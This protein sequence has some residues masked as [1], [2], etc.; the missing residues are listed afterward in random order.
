MIAAKLKQTAVVA[1]IWLAMAASAWAAP[2]E[3]E[4]KPQ[5]DAQSQNA[6][7]EAL[8]R[9]IEA[10]YIFPDTASQTIAAL[11]DKAQR[12]A[13][14]EMR[15]SEQFAAALTED[16]RRLA[17][18]KHFRLEF[19]PSFTPEGNTVPSTEQVAEE[20]KDVA[21]MAWGIRRVE[22][23]AGNVGYLD[24]R[25]FPPSYLVGPAYQSVLSLLS[26]TDA[27]ILDLRQNRGGDP[28]SV[29]QLLSYFFAPG[30]ERH[31]NDIYTRTSNTTRAFWTNP[32]VSLH[33]ARP[34]YVLTSSQTFSGGEECAYDFQTQQRG[35]LVGETTG[36][37]ANPVGPFVLP[38]G[39][40]VAIPIGRPINP[41]TKTNW[42]RVGVK[43][44]VPV[45]AAK[46]LE[47]A[48]RAAL[49]GLLKEAS[50]PDRRQS[51]QGVLARLDKGE[52]ELPAY[53]P[54]KR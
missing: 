5:L 47:T 15:S 10:N 26:G 12:G 8:A 18:D 50:D 25:G 40:V 53:R 39:F 35:T 14:R 9:Q 22:R 54:T 46:A 48:W 37:A 31:L 49:S 4:A 16:L 28:A 42:E 51:L 36:G 38:H 41:I 20:R 23:L 44:D 17:G 19:A 6:V 33:Y 43:P 34:V 29:A 13:Y 3:S 52:L 45:E 30:D 1:G 2:P 24:L 7:L 27:L 21:Q 11:K 32:A